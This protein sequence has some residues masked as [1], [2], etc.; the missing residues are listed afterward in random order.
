MDRAHPAEVNRQP[1]SRYTLQTSAGGAPGR[2]RPM[3]SGFIVLAAGAI[4]CGGTHW[5]KV[6]R[7]PGPSRLR[8]SE[9][10]LRL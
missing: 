1:Q 4:S 5:H 9:P 7:C 10:A 2:L 3:R 8:G 6:Q